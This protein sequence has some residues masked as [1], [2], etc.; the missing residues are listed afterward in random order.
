MKGSRGRLE[1]LQ[2]QFKKGGPL[3]QKAFDKVNTKGLEPFKKDKLVISESDILKST[4]DARNAAKWEIN[5]LKSAHEKALKKAEKLKVHAKANVNDGFAAYDAEN[6][7][8]IAN[9]I[10][11]R[12][13][14]AKIHHK[15]VVDLHE[16]ERLMRA[17]LKEHNGGTNPSTNQVV[18]Q[19]QPKQSNA[20]P[21]QFEKDY[22]IEKSRNLRVMKSKGY[23]IKG[24]YA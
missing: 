4:S 13:D 24:L 1:E 6:A 20:K 21:K 16:K 17:V 9:N 2:R 10:A 5:A 18:G 14:S 23:R 3:A 22:V 19:N 8:T 11:K 15:N 12:L 7:R